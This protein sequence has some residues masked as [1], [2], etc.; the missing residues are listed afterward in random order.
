MICAL[1]YASIILLGM[2]LTAA[3]AS[4]VLEIVS[5]RPQYMLRDCSIVIVGAAVSIG[6][7]VL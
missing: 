5:R 1:S 7:M 2:I 6:L 3:V 4:E